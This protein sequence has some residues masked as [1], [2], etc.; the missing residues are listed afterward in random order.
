MQQQ[1]NENVTITAALLNRSVAKLRGV[2]GAIVR[3]GS[4]GKS[5]VRSHVRRKRRRLG[6]GDAGGLDERSERLKRRGHA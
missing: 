3:S 1:R 5:G 6:Q 2:G 4:G